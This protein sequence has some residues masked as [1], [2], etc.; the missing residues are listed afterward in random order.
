MKRRY[1]FAII[2]FVIP[3]IYIGLAG[4]N[5]LLLNSLVFFLF[6]SFFGYLLGSIFGFFENKSQL[7]NANSKKFSY[8]WTLSVSA[9]LGTLVL[10]SFGSLGQLRYWHSDPFFIFGVL[11]WVIFPTILAFI[12]GYLFDRYGHNQ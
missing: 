5:L 9:F 6:S 8:S 12:I 3:A 7:R 11:S 4:E 10:A 2:F 1:L